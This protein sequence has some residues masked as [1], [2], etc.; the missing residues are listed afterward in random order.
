MRVGYDHQQP[1]CQPG[2]IEVC[3][4]LTVSLQDTVRDN[5]PL[6]NVGFFGRCYLMILPNTHKIK[7][8]FLVLYACRAALRSLQKGHNILF[9]KILC[10]CIGI[11]VSWHCIKNYTCQQSALEVLNRSFAAKNFACK[12]SLH[13]GFVQCLK[14]LLCF[15]LRVC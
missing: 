3:S 14:P 9:T 6:A 11:T 15:Y 7:H 13:I 10:V 12:A 1:A 8:S 4:P 5:R 2:L